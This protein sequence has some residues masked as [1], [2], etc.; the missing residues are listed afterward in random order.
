MEIS[1]N[2]AAIAQAV[3]RDMPEFD[4]EIA[5]SGEIESRVI[6]K[7]DLLGSWYVLMFYPR[8]F[9]FVC[10]TEIISFSSH[11][12]DFERRQCRVFGISADNIETHQQWLETPPEAGGLGA[13]KVPLGAD[14]DGKL[15]KQ[16][17]AW[18]YDQEVALRGLFIVNPDGVIQYSVVHSLSVGRNVE[19]VLRVL[20]ALQ[21]GGLCA[22]NWT[23]ADGNVD[24]EK[25]LM[26]GKVLG[27]YR[28]EQQLGQGSSG[29]VFEAWDTKLQRKV[30]L[31]VLRQNKMDAR[32]Q[33]LAEARTS[34][35]L[36]H[37]AICTIFSVEEQEG[38]PVIAMEHVHGC[39][40]KDR[41][42][43]GCD[44]FDL[45]TITTAIVSAL[46][47][48]HQRGVIHGDLKP[49]NI[50]L[51]EDGYPKLVDFGLAYR[52]N[53][54]WDSLQSG[55]ST[56]G[57]SFDDSTIDATV[58][59]GDP[60]ADSSIPGQTSSL[61]GTP[62][63]MSP[64]HIRRETVRSES[65]IYSLGLLVFELLTGKRLRKKVTLE[66]LLAKEV[67]IDLTEQ[68]LEQIPASW[69]KIITDMLQVSP[70]DRPDAKQLLNELKSRS[71]EYL[72]KA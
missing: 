10:P 3:D 60:L 22:A 63:Y 26:P 58:E 24:V 17:G 49:S 6:T 52:R 59:I 30:A 31:K 37:P 2:S 39:T 8:D 33:I 51:T 16:L 45:L 56:N 61:R 36:N 55:T 21:N 11:A 23:S 29:T 9:S 68:H 42:D 34:A 66:Q 1:T 57:D 12:A 38:L 43:H 72:P 62:A 47:Y 20:D 44:A 54:I 18:H 5:T 67:P 50:L 46:S 7:Q 53:A 25:A 71:R 14:E 64:E 13:I 40:L 41:L 70:D 28:I 69:K 19:E 65:D 35:Q 4:L 15:A 32:E 48:A 27:H